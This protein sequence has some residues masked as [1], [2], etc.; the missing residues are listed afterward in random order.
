MSRSHDL[1][2]ILL[3]RAWS[4]GGGGLY[5]LLAVDEFRDRSNLVCMDS[6]TKLEEVNNFEV[7]GFY[8]RLDV[9]RSNQYRVSAF[10]KMRYMDPS[11]PL[12][13]VDIVH[14]D[15]SR[16]VG[17]QYRTDGHATSELCLRPMAFRQVQLA[18]PL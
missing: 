10:Y 11:L 15:L 1:D 13:I 16:K 2:H 18:S 17:N 12:S 4:C 5:V 14:C 9:E 3:R 6:F 7:H 8:H